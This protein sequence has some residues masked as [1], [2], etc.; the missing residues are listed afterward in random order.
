MQGLKITAVTRFQPA[1]PA[2]S[3]G[4]IHMDSLLAYAEIL[5]IIDTLPP[6]SL[7][8]SP[9]DMGGFLK[10]VWGEGVE[11]IYAVSDMYPQGVTTTGKEYAHRRYPIDRSGL[12]KKSSANRAA[13]RYKEA[14]KSIHT[15]SAD[16]WCA[17]AIGDKEKISALL[18]RIPSIG[19]RGAAG[20]GRVEKWIVEGADWVTESLILDHKPIPVTAAND[21]DV[22]R[23]SIA[24][25]GWRNPYWY[26]PWFGEVM[27]PEQCLLVN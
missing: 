6:P 22:N 25:A 12:A 21:L 10:R 4:R 14:R 1:I 11:S 26:M 17:L 5:P 27:E 9:P 16:R 19:V 7:G 3:D 15:L 23:S 8:P 13:G 20:Y 24:V 2:T 18:E